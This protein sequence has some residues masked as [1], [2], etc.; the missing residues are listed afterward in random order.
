MGKTFFK[1][2]TCRLCKGKNLENVLPLTPTALC[3]AY[4]PRQLRQEVQEIYPLDLFLCL[5]CGYAHLPYVVDPEIIYRDYLYVTTSSLG[6]NEH[7]RTY[8]DEVLRRISPPAGSLVIDLGSNDGTLLKFFKN[9]GMRVLGIE[10]ATEIARAATESGVK[11]L[12]DFFNSAFAKNVKDEYGKAA[13]ITVNN[14]FANID[15]LE[16]FAH[17][18]NTLIA[19]DGVFIIESSYVADMIKNMVFD[20]IYHEHLSYLSVRPLIKFFDHFDM[21]LIDIE[22]IPTKGG[23]LRYYFQLKSGPR[24]VS[25]SVSKIVAYED[26]IGLGRPG[27]FKDFEKRINQR[28]S[29]LL[30]YLNKIR[31]QGNTVVGYGGSATSTTLIYHFGLGDMFSY[32]VD[33]NPAKQNTVSPG[34]HI[35]VLPSQALYEGKPDYVVLLAWRYVGSIVDRHRHFLREGGHFIQP[36][37]ELDVISNGR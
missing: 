23:S 19:D 31:G 20:F 33:D 5:D 34:F 6:L 24:P 29:E 10:P 14:L 30:N 25:P 21:E 7:F 35:P 18:I 28:K 15:D 11:T 9:K 36:L 1:R 16:D 2:N 4:L 27:I 12:P 3:D 32:I 13:V 8:T 17:G 22:R 26:S 37:P